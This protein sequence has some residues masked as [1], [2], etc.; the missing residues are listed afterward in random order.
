M[1]RIQ[2]KDEHHIEALNTCEGTQ[3]GK[4]GAVAPKRVHMACVIYMY[5]DP[6]HNLV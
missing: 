3:L 6:S 5:T 1:K 4:R 2:F